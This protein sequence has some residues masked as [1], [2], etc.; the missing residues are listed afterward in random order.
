[1]KPVFLYVNFCMNAIIMFKRDHF[2]V[3][4]I[5]ILQKNA[6]M[7]VSQPGRTLTVYVVSFMM[8]SSTKILTYAHC[9]GKT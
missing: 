4:W 6:A 1:M 2:L 7:H 5:P 3:V 9:T 8:T